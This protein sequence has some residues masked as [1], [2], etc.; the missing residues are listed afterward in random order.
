VKPTTVLHYV[1]EWL[2]LSD[3]FVYLPINASKR[4]DLVFSRGELQNLEVFP[5]PRVIP[6]MAA[7]GSPPEEG[8]ATASEVV[9]AL[10]AVMPDVIH[11]H[12]GY[13]IQ[14][15][16]ALARALKVPLVASYWGYDVTALP[17]ERGA[18]YV[19]LLQRPDRVI[20]PSRY[21]KAAVESLGVDQERVRVIPGPVDTSL[22]QA[23]P[24]PTE[25]HVL[26]VGRFVDKKGI[27]I[28]LRAWPTVLASVPAAFLTL[29]GYGDGLPTSN[30]PPRVVVRSP[31]L[32]TPR[33]Q[34]RDQLRSA[35]V[36]VSPSR[37]AA[38]GDA[39][40]QHIGNLEAQSSGRP[41]VTTQHGAIPEFVNHGATGLVVPENDAYALSDAL[42]DLL[43][44]YPLCQS[45]GKSGQQ[46]VSRFSVD[47]I[48][49]EFDNL[50]R[51]VL[52]DS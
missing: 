27:D 6:L 10:G 42:I 38:N 26:F 37:T 50:Y 2:W 49:S 12:H 15:A 24:V 40:S 41:V 32:G 45:L 29:L 33:L 36:Y 5:H 25:P 3:T 39:E 44:D 13:C 18:D 4:E 52:R 47:R 28:L 8:E 46:W 34:V 9:R 22:F 21:L 19:R 43:Q 1:T 14:D 17:R 31:D 11:L 20:V 35:R 48:C 23:T 30:L 7:G 16:V 51:E